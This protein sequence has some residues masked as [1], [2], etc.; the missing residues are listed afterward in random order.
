[1]G[2]N[3]FQFLP[4]GPYAGVV[5]ALLLGGPRIGLARPFDVGGPLRGFPR[6]DRAVDRAAPYPE[7]REHESDSQ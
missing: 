4:L 5:G 2:Q 6:T 1:M 7:Q 3:P